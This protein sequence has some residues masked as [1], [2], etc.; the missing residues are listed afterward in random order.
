MNWKNIGWSKN[1]WCRPLQDLYKDNSNII[2]NYSIESRYDFFDRIFDNTL[3]FFD[4]FLSML[5]SHPTAIPA[6]Y[7]KL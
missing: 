6:V 4:L 7:K 3:Y 5:T 2:F 1:T